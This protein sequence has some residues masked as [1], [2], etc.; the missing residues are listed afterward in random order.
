MLRDL[1]KQDIPFSLSHVIPHKGFISHYGYPF[2]FVS[3]KDAFSAHVVRM[4]VSHM[5]MTDIHV[6]N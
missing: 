5:E 4:T 6:H 3:L 1:E 2:V